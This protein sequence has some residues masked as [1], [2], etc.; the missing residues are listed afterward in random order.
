MI[1][2]QV[3]I[4]L[5]L[6]VQATSWFSWCGG[7]GLKAPHAAIHV[8]TGLNSSRVGN[9]SWMIIFMG[10][11]QECVL[12]MGTQGFK[13]SCICCAAEWLLQVVASTHALPAYQALQAAEVLQQLQHLLQH[14]CCAAVEAGARQAI[15]YHRSVSTL[16]NAVLRDCWRGVAPPLRGWLG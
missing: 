9:C 15:T 16:V 6:M 13:F 14:P 7:V 10:I 2:T 5:P 1:R 3:V 11:P 8:L 4:L 12:S